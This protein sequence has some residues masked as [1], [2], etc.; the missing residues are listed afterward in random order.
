MNTRAELEQIAAIGQS[1]TEAE[2]IKA[3]WTG[4]TP[5]EPMRFQVLPGCPADALRGLICAAGGKRRVD[6]HEVERDRRL[7]CRVGMVTITAEPVETLDR[8]GPLAWVE[9]VTFEAD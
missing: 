6:I 5:G 7:S 3:V 9:V 1:L 2:T 8:A 4:R